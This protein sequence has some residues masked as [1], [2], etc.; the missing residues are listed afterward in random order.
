MIEIET[1][2]REA[3]G[4]YKKHPKYPLILD[5]GIEGEIMEMRLCR[6]IF[7]ITLIFLGEKCFLSFKQAPLKFFF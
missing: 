3:P 5:Q 2:M 4:K 1:C 7:L 6:F